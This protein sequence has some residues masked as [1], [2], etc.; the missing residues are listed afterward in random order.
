MRGEFVDIGGR[1]LYYYAAGSRGSDVPVV[2]LHGFPVASR[3]WHTVTRDFPERHRL[4]VCDLP[5]FGRSEPCPASDCPSRATAVLA[6]LD[7]LRIER[8]AIV[9]HGLGG[10]VA[11]AVAL[12]A[13]ARVSHLALI[14]SAAF[15]VAP[16]HLARLARLTRL[17]G[18]LA[19]R[20]PPTL[21]AGLVHGT[22]IRGFAVR[23]RSRLTL[24]AGLQPFTARAGRDALV[25]HLVRLDD[26][27]TAT[28][29]A[30]LASLRIPT[31][32]LWGADDA[33]YPPALGERL[34]HTIPGATLDVIPGAGHFLP[35]DAPDRIITRLTELLSR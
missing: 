34:Q 17:L 19:R 27:S 9:G 4:V 11:Q 13:P 1:R 5:G 35:E 33:F 23:E 2:F 7:D 14:D 26:D 20:V 15:G 30:R 32:I 31:A 6:L 16:R 8:A 10:A 12:Q 22:V 18:P 28:L 25:A 24:D 29:S 21:L 3:L